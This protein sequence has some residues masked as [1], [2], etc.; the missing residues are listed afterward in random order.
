MMTI[1]STYVNTW[2]LQD[3]YDG[4][5]IIS[6]ILDI[7]GHLCLHVSSQSRKMI[8]KGKW[9]QREMMDVKKVTVDSINICTSYLVLDIEPLWTFSVCTEYKV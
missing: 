2:C 1:L 4:E 5:C 3:I 7:N 6:I 9:N 8:I